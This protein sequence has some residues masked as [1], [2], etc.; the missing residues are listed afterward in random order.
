M[1]ADVTL[2]LNLDGLFGEDAL[3]NA[4]RLLTQRV[5]D[6]FKQGGPAGDLVPRDTGTLQD[7]AMVTGDDEVTWPAEYA[8]AVYFGTERMPGRPWFDNGAAQEQGNWARYVGDV[9]LGEDR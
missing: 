1:A 6:D 8:E 3:A 7:T 9:L 2:D 5:A 4:Q